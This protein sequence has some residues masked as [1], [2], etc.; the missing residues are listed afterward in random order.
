ML[1]ESRACGEE[2]VARKAYEGKT[3]FPFVVLVQ[4]AMFYLMAY[5]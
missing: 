2:E 3:A 5:R 1:Y 4:Q